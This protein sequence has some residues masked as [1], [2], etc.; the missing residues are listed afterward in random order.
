MKASY[1]AA[2]APSSEGVSD[3]ASSCAPGRLHPYEQLG[4]CTPINVDCGRAS[5]NAREYELE[6]F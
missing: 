2:P 4:A 6:L 5:Q 3:L 1:A